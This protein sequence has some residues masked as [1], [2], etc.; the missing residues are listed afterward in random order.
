MKSKIVILGHSGFIG[1]QLK[2]QLLRSNWEVTGLSLPNIDLTIQSDVIKLIPFFKPETIIIIAAAIKKQFGDTFETYLQNLKIIE[3]ICKLIQMHSVRR[4]IYLSSAA[5]YGEETENLNI[6]ESTL[7]NP[8]SYYGINKFMGER[9]LAKVCNE[10][11]YTTLV[12]LRPPLIYGPN[13]QGK[14][15][16]PSGFVSA[17]FEGKPIRL[18]GD[19]SELREFMYIED[20]C[21]VIEFLL[22]NEF[23]GELNVVSGNSYRFTDVIDILKKKLINIEVYSKLRSKKLVNNT[24]NPKKIKELLPI[25]F[26]FTDLESGIENILREQKN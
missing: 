22:K 17:A 18:W 2:K 9:L 11:Q 3:N 12:C 14:T 19:G 23:E 8:T 6:N 4:I 25:N 10:N 21:N 26:N 7:V 15:Y 16:G 13:D 1:T 20:L 24:F 5:V